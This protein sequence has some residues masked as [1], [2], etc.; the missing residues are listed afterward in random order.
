MLSPSAPHYIPGVGGIITLLLSCC[1]GF[2]LEFYDR[3]FLVFLEQS[4]TSHLVHHSEQERYI[5]IN[6]EQY[7][8][9][10]EIREHVAHLLNCGIVSSIA[11]FV[12]SCCY[13]K[14]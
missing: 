4:Q 9:D 7:G 14:V 2:L 6:S 3:T 5:L 11:S 1:L 10:S 12:V 13:Y 8:Q